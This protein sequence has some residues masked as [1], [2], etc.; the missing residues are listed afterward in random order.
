MPKRK[1][2]ELSNEHAVQTSSSHSHPHE[3][4]QKQ[5]QKLQSQSK[6]PAQVE[7]LVQVFEHGSVSIFRALKVARGFERQ[8]LGRRE[9]TAKVKDKD[10]EQEEQRRTLARLAEEIVV[11]KVR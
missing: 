5:K 9:K 10:K 8:K 3:K 2:S 1:L 6:L 11:L 7:R 4:H